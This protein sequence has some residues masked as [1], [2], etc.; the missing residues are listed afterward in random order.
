MID[1]ALMRDA[2][3]AT[4]LK[5]KKA[6]VERGLMMLVRLHRQARIKDYYGKLKW[7][8]DLRESRRSR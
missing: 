3:R 2:L 5:T 6:V 7:E 1:D 4:G 8:G